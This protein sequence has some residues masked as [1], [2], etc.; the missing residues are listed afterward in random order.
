MS[1]NQRPSLPRRGAPGQ[2]ICDAYG[3][4]WVFDSETKSW[5]V[6]G[7]VT[8]PPVVTED[9]S[10]IIT[11]SIFG[12]LQK[13]RSLVDSGVDLTPLKLLPG[14]DGYWYYFYSS[15]K[16]FR[17]KPEGPDTLRIEIDRGKIY[18]ILARQ[19]CPGSRGPRGDKGIDGDPGAGGLPEQCYQPSIDG[20]AL[21]FAIFTPVPLQ[22]GGNVELP[23]DRVP[24]ISVRL[25]EI[26]NPSSADIQSDDQ[27]RATAIYLQNNDPDLAIVPKFEAT[28]D[29]LR[30]QALG[31]IEA[32]IAQEL[33][34]VTV[35][36]DSSIALEPTVT[37]EIDPT[38]TNATTISIADG[39]P[40]ID[41]P[42][43]LDSM[44]YDAVTGIVCGT[45]YLA[46][47][48]WRDSW[49]VK[50]RQK[51]P[52]GNQGE[53]GE[54]R[55]EII[56]CTIDDTNI[57]ATCPI[58]NVR[59]DC[60]LD[61]IYTL[62]SDLVDEYC[63]SQIALQPGSDALANTNALKSVFAAAEMTLEECKRIRRYEVDLDDDNVDDPD[64][65]NWEPQDGCVTRR[66]YDRHKF[67]WVSATNAPAC[68]QNRWWG[69]DAAREAVYPYELLVAGVP[70]ADECCADDFFFCPN[71]QDGACEGDPPGPPP[72]PV[73]PPGPPTPPVPPP[74]PPVPPPGPPV[75][76][77]GQPPVS[78]PTPPPFPPPFP[79]PGPPPPF[80]PPFPPPTP[81]PGPP[82][83][84]TPPPTPPPSSP[85]SL[86]AMN[87]AARHSIGA[88]VSNSHSVV[89][90]G[91][92][93][94]NVNV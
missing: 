11:P 89:N 40:Q 25:T 86:A 75:P 66:H 27:L 45:F 14:R 50:S 29:L 38:G 48:D 64:L 93:A 80:P 84:P 72:P 39:A 26:L 34:D 85:S 52:D 7:T 17:F 10:G 21:S 22:L 3:N 61:L 9:K 53:P 44:M 73:P 47:E 41:V 63:A 37:I 49:C 4:I 54:C 74:G 43:T 13:L 33:S 79:P 55:V 42:R 68:G 90:Q 24:E 60:Q 35:A 57:V 87:A 78:P 32:Q 94:W 65:P 83:P 69:P 12:Q 82:T 62:C 46:D 36:A 19:A 59:V 77:P 18:H 30:R 15:D 91:V 2:E 70:P 58:V 23:G 67:D 6:R 5:I 16:T 1:L 71:V 81:P 8:E 31:E 88:S 76:P 28:R 56:E 20:D 51:G 92:R